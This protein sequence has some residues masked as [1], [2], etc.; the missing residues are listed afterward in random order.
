M[1]E[2][3]TLCHVPK[4]GARFRIVACQTTLEFHPNQ[5]HSKRLQPLRLH[6]NQRNGASLWRTRSVFQPTCV[7][8]LSLFFIAPCP[9]YSLTRNAND[10][11][12]A[13]SKVS[14]KSRTPRDLG[15]VERA[16]SSKLSIKLRLGRLSLAPSPNRA[17]ALIASGRPRWTSHGRSNRFVFQARMGRYILCRWPAATGPAPLILKSP[18]WGD[19][20]R[21]SSPALSRC[22]GPSGHKTRG[23]SDCLATTKASK[24]QNQKRDLR[25]SDKSAVKNGAFSSRPVFQPQMTPILADYRA[26]TFVV[27]L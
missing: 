7:Q 23:S 3:S 9:A 12:A 25:P 19:T 10:H 17:H 24:Q 16:L 22:V 13:A 6:A 5:G 15:R 14:I 21:S 18:E 11:L 4:L 20:D 27:I 2:K 8:V 26:F 1:R